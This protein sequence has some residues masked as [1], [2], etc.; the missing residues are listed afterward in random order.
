VVG[1][2]YTRLIKNRPKK[3]PKT[4]LQTE[5]PLLF[6]QAPETKLT[7]SFQISVAEPKGK[8]LNI[9]KKASQTVQATTGIWPK[10]EMTLSEFLQ[11]SQPKLRNAASQFSELTKLAERALYSHH[12]PEQQ[13]LLKAEILLDEIRRAL[14]K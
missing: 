5:S 14:E 10:P 6:E 13:D 1:L 4:T 2:A 11:E 8:L 12:V 3:E 9:Y 7:S